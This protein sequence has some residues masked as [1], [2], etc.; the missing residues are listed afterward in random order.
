MQLTLYTDYSLR[1]LI[2]LGSHPEGATIPQ[3]SCAFGIN[4]NHLVKVAHHLG[5]LGYIK[6]TRGK[7]GGLRLNVPA[8]KLVVGHVVRA[9]EDMRLVECFNR[10][11]GRCPITPVCKLKHVLFEA[12]Q[13]FLAT[14]DQYTLA[15]LLQQPEELRALLLAP[16]LIIE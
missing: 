15:D 6:T 12:Q 8:E 9:V 16:A 11:G 5:R 13:A 1:L 3:V 7:S 14:L 4:R 2:Y 10:D